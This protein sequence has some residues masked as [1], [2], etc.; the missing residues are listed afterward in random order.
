[1]GS[2]MNID[3]LS[4]Y[5]GMKKSSLY[6]M[7][8]RREIP[9]YKIGRLLRFQKEEVEMWL[10]ERRQDPWVHEKSA[11]RI[12]PGLSHSRMDPK[13]IDRIVSRN[14]A[15]ATGKVYTSDYGRSDQ[16]VRGLGK[17]AKNGDL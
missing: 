6:S 3:E 17:E 13:N 2:L 16:E 5:L 15:Q 10:Q 8:E 4:Q 11:K 7:V 12:M 14:I 9:F 1:M